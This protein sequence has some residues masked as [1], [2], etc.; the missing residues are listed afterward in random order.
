MSEKQKRFSYPA[1][2]KLEVIRYAEEHGNKAAARLFGPSPTAAMI[3]VW[4]SRK[5]ELVKMPKMKRAAR[6]KTAKWPNLERK[7][8]QWVEDQ[9]ETGLCVSTK[10]LMDKGRRIAEE[11][12]KDNDLIDE[13][14]ECNTSDGSDEEFLDYFHE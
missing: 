6:G 13:L 8:K 10:M 7:L 4:R 3:G 5:D 12:K 9:R 2:F 14:P 1:N 11:M